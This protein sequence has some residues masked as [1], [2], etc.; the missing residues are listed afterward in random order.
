MIEAIIKLDDN[1]MEACLE[2]NMPDNDTIWRLKGTCAVEFFPVLAGS[3]FKNK[4]V[5][6]LLDV[7]V[8]FLSS[9]TEVLPIKGINPKDGSETVRKVVR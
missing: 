1:A 7:V 5:Q 8:N 2:G 4:G 3:A 6:P 9:P